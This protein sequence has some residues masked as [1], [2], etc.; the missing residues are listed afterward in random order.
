MSARYSIIVREHGSD[1]NVELM[2]VGSNPQA[3]VDGLRKKTLKI[4]RSIFEPGKRVAKIPKYSFI[5]IIDH[6]A[7]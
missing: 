5:Q 1:H 6:E 4:S 2:Q 7:Q 3:I